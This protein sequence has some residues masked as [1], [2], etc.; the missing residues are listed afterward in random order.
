MLAASIPVI[1]AEL[2]AG[3][4]RAGQLVQLAE[5]VSE[6]LV[7]LTSQGIEAG[8]CHGDVTADNFNVLE[9]GSL[10]LY[11][12]SSSA[13]GMR[14]GDL[15]G[16]RMSPNWEAF[17]RGFRELREVEA[18][19]LEAIDWMV[20]PHQLDNARWHLTDFRQLRGEEAVG[21]DYVDGVLEDMT[22]WATDVLGV[23]LNGKPAPLPNPA[24]GSA[25]GGYRASPVGLSRWSSSPSWCP[26]PVASIG[27]LEAVHAAYELDW[28][29]DP[30]DIG[31]SSN[32]NLHLPDTGYGHVLRVHRAWVSPPRLEAVQ[33]VRTLLARRGLPF[34]EPVPT[35]SGAR[36]ITVG[37]HL[38][39]VERCVVGEDMDQWRTLMLGMPV[40]A[41]IHSELRAVH[42]QA[43]SVAPVANHVDARTARIAAARGAAIIRS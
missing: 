32:L 43:A 28:E 3:D 7:A 19:E 39:E 20:V 31:G 5:R 18:I 15:T 29:G 23:E 26:R 1:V 6:K 2:P 40:L 21:A 38:A 4:S 12:F 37:M 27:L 13:I 14:A 8:L 34:V 35:K 41:R 33:S 17:L 24:V 10:A 25:T 36:F 11:D 22:R 42:N 30:V 16:V 9:D